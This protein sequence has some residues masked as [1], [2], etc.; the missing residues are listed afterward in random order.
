MQEVFEKIIE[1]LEEI[2][3]KKTC[4]K[5]KCDTKELCRICVVDDAI[6]I[7]KQE[8]E[9]YNNYWIPCSERL[10]EESESIFAKYKG[11]E[12]WKDNMFEKM[13]DEVNV[14]IEKEDGKRL[15][16]HAH[17]VD[18]KWKNDMLRVYETWRVI[19]WQPLP[20]TYQPNGENEKQTNADRIRSMSDEEL[21]EFIEQ[22][23]ADS[24]DTISFGTKDY[25]EIWEHKETA[26]KWLQSEVEE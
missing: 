13:S 9:K 16:M 1:K 4:K 15:T 7:V 24:M 20:A 8:A 17:T 5:E 19:A 14:T 12:K 10:P 18:G 2:R 11:T 25:E 21:A 22:I 26:L 6:E 3:I 23:S